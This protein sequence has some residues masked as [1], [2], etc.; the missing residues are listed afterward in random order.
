MKV[1]FVYSR[2]YDLIFHVLSHIKVENASD[3]YDEQYIKDIAREKNGP[4]YDVITAAQTIQDYYNSNFERLGV[5]NF[6]PYFCDSYDAMKKAFVTY[7]QFTQE[8]IECFIKPLNEILNKESAFFFE[9]W[10]VLD[11]E[12]EPLKQK[13]EMYFAEKLGKYSCVFNYF[14]KLCK[15]LMSHVITR[16]GRG[17]SFDSSHFAA[18]IRFPDSEKAYDFSFIQLLHEYTH[19]FTDSLLNMHISMNDGSHSLSENVVIVADYYLIKAVDEKLIPRYFDWVA[20]GSN[21]V[22]NEQDF[23]SRFCLDTDLNSKLMELLGDILKT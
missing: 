4:V 23:L 16:N 7:E 10:D 2:H 3:L 21:V 14:G 18:L 12:R 19:G 8:D 20:N 13:A 22:L 1:D 6:L 15:V 17:F 11:K 5:I 9:Y